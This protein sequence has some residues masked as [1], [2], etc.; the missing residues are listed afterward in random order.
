MPWAVYFNE[1][2]VEFPHF[3]EPLD[4]PV[5]VTPAEAVLMR[6]Q[7]AVVGFD[8]GGR[9]WAIPWWVMKNHHV[10]N[11]MIDGEAV[12][13][14]LCEMCSGGGVFDPVIEGQRLWFWHHGFFRGG[15][16][17][18]DDITGS[19]WAAV[20]GRPLAGP[21]VSMGALP[22][23]PIIH[24]TWERWRD[25][26]PETLVVHG[27]NEPRDGH[28]AHETG[29]DHQMA[30]RAR[31]GRFDPNELFLTVELDER[32]RAYPLAAIHDAG[33]VINDVTA[34]R[35]IV[36][37]A[38]GGTWLAM[39]FERGLAGTLVELRWKVSG[40]R[41]PVLVDMASGSRFDPWGRCFAGEH[42]GEALRYIRS[43]LRKWSPL[44][45]SR[46]EFDLW[47]QDL[48]IS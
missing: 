18:T 43:P 45:F 20:T 32:I 38:L 47:E 21:G 36:A 22:V 27:E 19:A 1:G 5:W 41:E 29:P 17:M 11:L 23:R 10:A 8:A 46:A 26:Y 48:R 6:D 24:A 40:R 12:L 39:A 30:P 4:E 35:M 33:G 42:A 15:P 34:G 25:M 2:G 13:V 16:L 31:D 44:V 14:T 9:K 37:A 28:G 3:C 7:D